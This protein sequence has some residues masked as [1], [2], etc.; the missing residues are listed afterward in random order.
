M[1]E[2][3]LFQ[4]SS[5]PAHTEELTVSEERVSKSADHQEKVSDEQLYELPG[6]SASPF[7]KCPNINTKA[8]FVSKRDDG[9]INLTVFGSIFFD[10]V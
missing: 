4:Q 6:F 2:M 1:M 8:Y 9:I 3:T 5:K 7:N 10:I